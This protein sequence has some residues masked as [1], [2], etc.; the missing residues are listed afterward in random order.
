MADGTHPHLQVR[1]SYHSL[2]WA[3]MADSAARC[4]HCGRQRKI[5]K[6]CSV[7]QQTWYCGAECQNAGWKKHKKTC[8]PPPLH[9]LNVLDLVAAAHESNDW[10][11]VL[12]WEGRLEELMGC[13]GGTGEWKISVLYTFITAYMDGLSATLSTDSTGYGPSAVRLMEKRIELFGDL[14][15]L[16]D[17]GD[18]M[19]NLASTLFSLGHIK[20]AVTQFERARALGAAHGFFS[21]ECA[22]CHGLGE[23]AIRDGRDEEGLDLLRNALVS[24][25]P[26]TLDPRPQNLNPKPH[27]SN[28]KP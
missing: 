17:Q 26:Q 8:T 25:K 11:G 6:R 1:P 18:H 3:T 12:E 2:S 23:L 9:V 7:C 5:L 27:T 13:Y 24:P 15:R 19:C 14:E 10:R 20:D 28:P 22:A 21:V 16:R 4:S